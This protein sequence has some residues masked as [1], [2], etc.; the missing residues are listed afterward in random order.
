MRIK[1]VTLLVCMCYAAGGMVK[2]PA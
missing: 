1:M 2:L